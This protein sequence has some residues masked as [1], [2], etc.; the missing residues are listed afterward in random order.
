MPAIAITPSV[1]PWP[2]LPERER[3]I[4]QDAIAVGID[5]LRKFIT[6]ESAHARHS[7]QCPRDTGAE[8]EVL[9]V[10]LWVLVVTKNG[11]V[12]A[13][14]GFEGRTELLRPADARIHYREQVVA[15]VVVRQLIT[16]SRGRSWF[17]KNCCA[18]KLSS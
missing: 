7:R 3:V 15:S 1:T 14:V 17:F 16:N 4:R 10:E 13:D 6:R 8:P 9:E 5:E 18:P 11:G 12:E 2:R